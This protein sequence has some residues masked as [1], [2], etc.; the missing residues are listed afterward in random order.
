MLPNEFW[1]EPP[2]NDAPNPDDEFSLAELLNRDTV[3][4]ATNQ[5]TTTKLMKPNLF[6][7][8]YT[9]LYLFSIN[10]LAKSIYL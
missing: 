5:D 2:P 4:Y 6:L 7:A 1:L 9:I 8:K 10:A 3:L